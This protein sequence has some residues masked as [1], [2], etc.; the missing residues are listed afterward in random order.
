MSHSV[1][2][3]RGLKLQSQLFPR[4]RS[5]RPATSYG[6][7][8]AFAQM[9]TGRSHN[10]LKCLPRIPVL[11]VGG[12]LS[13]SSY[14]LVPMSCETGSCQTTD[15]TVPCDIRG[16]P[17]P[18]DPDWNVIS[19]NGA[20]KFNIGC[21]G[22]IFCPL[23]SR[24]G[25]YLFQSAYKKL[26][27]VPRLAASRTGMTNAGDIYFADSLVDRLTLLNEAHKQSWRGAK[28]CK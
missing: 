10:F 24:C 18:L 4:A 3:R 28:L 27:L 23:P 26:F 6:L 25:R 8:S 21:L 19:K 11:S 7:T 12:L 16:P 14:C 9:F 2:L 17:P 22:A 5:R 13:S 15:L 1:R 20:P